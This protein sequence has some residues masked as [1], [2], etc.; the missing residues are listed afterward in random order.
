MIPQ[1]TL[2]LSPAYLGY[3]GREL[4]VWNRRGDIRPTFI[5]TRKHAVARR[6][7]I[8]MG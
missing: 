4:A 3:A 7:E 2:S 1:S 5:T 6:D 8:V